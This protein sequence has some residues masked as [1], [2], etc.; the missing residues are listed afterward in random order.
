MH[1]HLTLAALATLWCACVGVSIQ[2]PPPPPPRSVVSV[3]YEGGHVAELRVAQEGAPSGAYA[4]GEGP[5]LSDRRRSCTELCRAG[6]TVLSLF[7]CLFSF[8][9]RFCG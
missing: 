2:A 1:S 6:Q 3:R 9:V 8:F 7:L 4:P 5:S